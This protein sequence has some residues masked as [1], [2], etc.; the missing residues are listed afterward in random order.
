MDGSGGRSGNGSAG[1]GAGNGSAGGSGDAFGFAFADTLGEDIV[2]LAVRPNGTLAS[3]DVLRFGLAGSELVRLAGLGRVDVVEGRVVVLDASVVG[4]ASLDAALA[5]FGAA[6]K[7]PK[8]KDWV[9]R[10][11]SDVT[12]G[13]LARL[14]ASG[15]LR[16]ERSQ[17]LKVFHSTR[18]RVLDVA[19]VAALTARASRIATSSGPVATEDGAFAGL[20]YAVGLGSLLFPGRAGADARR[21]LRDIAKRE[22]SA[23]RALGSAVSGVEAA[24]R[25]AVDASVD[26]SVDAAVHAAVSA[27]HHAT[28]SHAGHAGGGAGGGHH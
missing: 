19:R 15:T 25:A 7:P 3:G 4:D 18:W 24:T 27:A 14:E 10:A 21:R 13:Y 28:T 5:A 16:S 12:R 11:K 8:A 26:A 2:L 6:G 23:N 9:G 20:L 1:G 17:V 22:G